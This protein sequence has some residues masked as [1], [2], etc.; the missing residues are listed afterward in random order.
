MNGLT[1][2]ITSNLEDQGAYCS[3]AST[4]HTCSAWLDLPGAQDSHWYSSGGHWGIQAI[5]PLQ[6]RCT[7]WWSSCRRPKSMMMT[8]RHTCTRA[9]AHIHL[10]RHIYK[11]SAENTYLSFGCLLFPLLFLLLLLELRSFR[12]INWSSRVQLLTWA[13]TWM[14]DLYFTIFSSHVLFLKVI[15]YV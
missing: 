4:P 12:F 10:H 14:T 13:F 5:I 6:G 15:Y 8:E 2:C 7:W 9:Y 1:H 3:L 11:R